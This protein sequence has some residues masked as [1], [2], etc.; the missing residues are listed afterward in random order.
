MYG[1]ECQIKD[2]KVHRGLLKKS[3]DITLQRYLK[4]LPPSDWI[5]IIKFRTANHRLPIEIYS[6]QITYKERNKRVCTMCNSGDIGDEFHYLLICPMFHEARVKFIAKYFYKKPSV[7]KFLQLINTEV[8]SELTNLSKFLKIL[9][10][11]S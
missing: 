11:W 2:V 3:E 10:R 8:R 7:F 1:C 6:W 4:I 5:P 9:V